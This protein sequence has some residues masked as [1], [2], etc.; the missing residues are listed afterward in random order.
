MKIYILLIFLVI[1][2]ELFSQAYIK[3][4]TKKIK[5]GNSYI[6]RVISLSTD[7][8][9]T[10][11][12]INKRS[13]KSYK[14]NSN[15]FGLQIVFSSVGP[16]SGKQQ[17]GENPSYIT[18]NDFSFKGFEI[19]D[20]DSVKQLS[21]N[22]EL[23][24]YQTSLEVTEKYEIASEDF[25]IRKYLEVK[26]TSYGIHFLD[27]IIVEDLTIE[28]S[29]Y[30][31][32]QF[33][34]PVFDNDI[35][36]GVE[37]PAAENKIEK[38]HL[39]VGY[40]VGQ[41]IDNNLYPSYPSILGASVSPDKLEETFLF[42]VDRIKVNG[43]RPYILYNSWYDFRNP[44]IAEDSSS[45]MNE[46]NVLLRIN[47]FKE[48]LFNKYN[49]ALNAFVLDDGWDNYKSIWSIDTVTLPNKFTPFTEALKSMNTSLGI[50]ASPF[51]GYSNRDV[52]VNWAKENGYETVADFFCFAGTKY[53]AEFKRRC[54]IMQGSI[55]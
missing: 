16:A 54:W 22:F 33:G 27:K 31:H 30:S 32:G 45:I 24:G 10:T 53:K 55:I 34:Q 13:K 17:N 5:I 35:F 41:K 49:I 3:N 48:Y 1:P 26:D 38:D 51:G 23:E 28:N 14:A 4:E 8:F 43:N 12:I 50:W 2:A 15:E 25:Y 40:V 11:E 6:E 18:A 42:Y 21:L 36:L 52:R 37:Y 39:K 29:S 46:K 44:A 9:G 7:N 19:S 20:K 47:T